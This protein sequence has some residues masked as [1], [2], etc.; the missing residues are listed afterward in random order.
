L[1]A[2]NLNQGACGRYE[3]LCL[4]LLPSHL[5]RLWIHEVTGSIENLVIRLKLK[6]DLCRVKCRVICAE[7]IIFVMIKSRG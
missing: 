6:E 7:E 3:G 4:Q 5:T 2:G 1:I